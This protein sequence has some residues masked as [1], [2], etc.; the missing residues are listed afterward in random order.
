MQEVHF[1][2]S[3]KPRVQISNSHFAECE[4]IVS[5]CEALSQEKNKN[6]KLSILSLVP[7]FHLTIIFKQDNIL[8]KYLISW[9]HLILQPPRQ[10]NVPAVDL[11]LKFHLLNF[12]CLSLSLFCITVK[13]LSNVQVSNNFFKSIFINVFLS[14]VLQDCI[15][16]L[17]ILMVKCCFVMQ[18]YL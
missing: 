1:L 13:W 4:G 14:K 8:Q 12:S 11:T 17:L 16:M 10:A 15:W 18:H 5:F 3:Q 2:T 7:K 6:A 9:H